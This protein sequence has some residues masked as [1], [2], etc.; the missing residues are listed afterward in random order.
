MRAEHREPAPCLRSHTLRL[1]LRLAA[2]RPG[3][4]SE[5]LLSQSQAASPLLLSAL[6]EVSGLVAHI[7]G[8]CLALDERDLQHRQEKLEGVLNVGGTV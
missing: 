3:A 6:S 5:S 1:C 4:K 2:G 8:L 7:W